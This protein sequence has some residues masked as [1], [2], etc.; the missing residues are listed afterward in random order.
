MADRNGATFLEVGLSFVLGVIVGT[1]LALLYAPAP[2]QETRRVLREKTE[3][4]LD[5][6]EL[7]AEQAK[8]RLRRARA[9]GAEAVAPAES[10]GELT[11]EPAET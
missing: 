2:G 1:T 10:A 6:A 4:I 8:T 9:R 11:E 3:E 7:V 5:K